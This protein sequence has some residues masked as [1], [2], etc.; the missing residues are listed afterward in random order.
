MLNDPMTQ[1]IEGMPEGH[2]VLGFKPE[3]SPVAES[4]NRIISGNQ[5]V[6]KIEF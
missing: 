4:A 3:N 2:P 6:Q 5:I 1:V